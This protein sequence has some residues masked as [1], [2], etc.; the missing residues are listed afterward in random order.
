[1]AVFTAEEL[2]LM[3]ELDIKIKLPKRIDYKVLK[4]NSVCFLCKTVVSQYFEMARMENEVWVRKEEIFF[5]E[6][7]KKLEVQNISKSTCSSCRFVLSKKSKEELI[8]M[9]I[10]HRTFWGLEQIK[11]VVWKKAK[12]INF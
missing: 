10:E 1:M 3:Q 4:V 8:A 2:L 7:P 6:E 11:A 5:D 9:L 12:E